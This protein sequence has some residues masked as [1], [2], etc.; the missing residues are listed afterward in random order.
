MPAE[1]TN[2]LLMMLPGY[3]PFIHTGGRNNAAKGIQ[4]Q[5]HPATFGLWACQDGVLTYSQGSGPS[6]LRLHGPAAVFV[7]PGAEHSVSVTPGSQWFYLRFDVVD[8]PRQRISGKQAWCHT[9]P[10][11]Q[12]DPRTI[13]GVDLVP[14]VPAHFTRGTIQLLRDCCA[15]WWRNDHYHAQAN[16]A[17]GS[18]LMDYVMLNQPQSALVARGQGLHQQCR[19]LIHERLSLHIDV[20]DLAAACGYSRVHFTRRFKAVTGM[21]PS[22]FIREERMA[23]ACQLLANTDDHLHHVA[24]AC[25][26]RSAAAFSRAFADLYGSTP[27]TWRRKYR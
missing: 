11:D 13:W 8:Q 16:A 23:R 19:D 20:A 2:E 10:I 21:N 5:K 14:R 4:E 9:G 18:W 6:T 17:L 15:L 26:Y 24:T 1:H 27:G 3:G 22:Y 25:G 12:P 7:V